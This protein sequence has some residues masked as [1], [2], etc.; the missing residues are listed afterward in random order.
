MDSPHRTAVSILAALIFLTATV[1]VE[2]AAP[3]IEEVMS[4][5]GYTAEQR[6]ALLAGKIVT[7][8]LER[9][10]G[11]QLIAAA[12]MRLPVDIGTLF[13]NVA[14]G[15][16]LEADPGIAAIGA[17]GPDPDAAD[18]ESLRFTEQDRREAEKLLAYRGGDDFNLHGDETRVLRDG[19][20]SVSPRAPDMLDKVSAAYRDLLA[21]RFTAYQ[22]GGLAGVA[23]YQRGGDSLHPAKELGAVA[24]Q[25]KPFLTEFFP[26]FWTAFSGFPA[27]QTPDAMNKFYWIKRAVEGRPC[28]ILVHEMIAGGDSHV[29]LT[30]REFFVGHTYESLQVVALALPADNGVAVFYVNAA[31]TEQITGFFSGVAESVGQGRMKDD[32]TAYF[33]AVKKG[34]TD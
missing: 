2:A 23:P 7:T 6:E 5:L 26:E 25:T 32:L 3:S 21:G 10:R 15:S 24:D 19:L 1:R 22:K 17:L 29:L 27:S 16:G 33:T 28:F 11:D 14:K 31:F 20:K 34:Q 9:A 4:R 18:W 8:D 13:D 30:R 12:G